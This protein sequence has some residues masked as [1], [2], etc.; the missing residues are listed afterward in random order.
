VAQSGGS[1]CEAEN[2][3]QHSVTISDYSRHVSKGEF[4]PSSSEY[5]WKFFI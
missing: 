1:F 3:T 5:L 4:L 2:N